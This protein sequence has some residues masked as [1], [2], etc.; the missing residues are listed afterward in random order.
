MNKLQTARRPFDEG[1]AISHRLKWGSLP[2]NEVGRIAQHIIQEGGR[3]E[4]KVGPPFLLPMKAW[5][6]AATKKALH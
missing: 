1:Y 4:G 3:K 2:P 6:V 5:T